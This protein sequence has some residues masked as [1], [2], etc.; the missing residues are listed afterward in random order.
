[1]EHTYRFE[2]PVLVSYCV[3]E[4]NLEIESIKDL[5]KLEKK[6]DVDLEFVIDEFECKVEIEDEL[7]DEDEEYSG[8]AK[9]ELFDS[10]ITESWNEIIDILSVDVK[11]SNLDD[12]DVNKVFKITSE[13]FNNSHLETLY[14]KDSSIE[15][16]NNIEIKS[17]LMN[18]F[19]KNLSVLYVDITVGKKLKDEQ[20]NEIIKY[21][22]GQC[23][24]GWGE[25]FEQQ[26]ISHELN[27]DERYV[28]VKTW[29]SNSEVKLVK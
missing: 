3:D 10:V 18:E 14:N 16:D 28:Y 9:D 23:S 17:M 12:H 29:S 20:V 22:D 13:N 2:I 6:Y 19:D 27:E 26:D 21:I 25:G 24:D 8:I 4:S 5:K 11:L 1:M 15:K 7:M